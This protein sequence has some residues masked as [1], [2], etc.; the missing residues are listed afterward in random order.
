MY[1]LAMMNISKLNKDPDISRILHPVSIF[2]IAYEIPALDV[3]R[4][5]KVPQLYYR[6]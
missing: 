6:I 4:N 2:R 3:E 1:A 5:E